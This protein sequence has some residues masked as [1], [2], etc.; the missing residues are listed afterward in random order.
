VPGLGERRR[1]GQ[2]RRFVERHR[3]GE[4]QRHRERQRLGERQQ[5]GER[6]WVKIKISKN[7]S[8]KKYK[9]VSQIFRLPL[10]VFTKNSKKYFYAQTLMHKKNLGLG[11]LIWEDSPDTCAAQ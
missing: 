4:R 10:H 1:L 5:L 3:L 11:P 6:Q 2:R 7:L 8:G 9:I